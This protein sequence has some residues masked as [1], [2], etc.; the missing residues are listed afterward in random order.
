MKEKKIA[1]IILLLLLA[2]IIII[3]CFAHRQIPETKGG[4]FSYNTGWQWIREDG[5]SIEVSLPVNLKLSPDTE[6]VLKNQVPEDFLLNSGIVFRSRQQ[7]VKVYVS[8]R[9]IYA[10]P[11]QKL[12]GGSLPIPPGSWQRDL[13]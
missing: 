3:E 11:S 10:Y 9:L 8:G 4:I 6:L 5:E 7:M 2:F 12:N 13:C 1:G